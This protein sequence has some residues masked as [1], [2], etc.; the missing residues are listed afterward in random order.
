MEVD[1]QLNGAVTG[2]FVKGPGQVA[3]NI[4]AAAIGNWAISNG[5]NYNYYNASGIFGVSR[6]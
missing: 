4:P 1:S 5:R 6:H 3:G 2:S